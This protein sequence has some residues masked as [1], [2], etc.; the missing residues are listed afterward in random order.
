MFTT[1]DAVLIRSLPYP[2]SERLVF[3]WF[4]PPNDHSQKS[5]ATAAEFLVLERKAGCSNT[6][7]RWRY[8]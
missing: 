3:I 7:R 4:T 2:Y 1:I 8:W 5:A 6:S